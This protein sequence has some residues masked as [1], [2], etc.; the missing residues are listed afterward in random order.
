[1]GAAVAA[2]ELRC[3]RH[4]ARNWGH[5]APFVVPAAFAACHCSPHCFITLWAHDPVT[6]ATEIVATKANRIGACIRKASHQDKQPT[7]SRG[8]NRVSP[9]PFSERNR[10]TTAKP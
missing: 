4:W 7:L 5:V 3:A 2:P 9:L 10:L 1:V 6:I 8:R